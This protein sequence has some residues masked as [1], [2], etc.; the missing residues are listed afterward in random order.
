MAFFKALSLDRAYSA[1][2]FAFLS[3]LD[4][5]PDSLLQGVRGLG[6]WPAFKTAVSVQDTRMNVYFI[7]PPQGDL[8][9]VR[10]VGARRVPASRR[11]Q[12]AELLARAN[13]LLSLG[14]LTLDLD[15]GEIAARASIDSEGMDLNAKILRNLLYTVVSSMQEFYPAVVKLVKSD[16]GVEDC[17][18]ELTET[19]KVVELSM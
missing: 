8:L 16:L 1:F 5:L 10:A 15:D 17:L 9:I 12:V 7:A 14:V 2:S 4:P 13:L 19:R 18:R 6:S 3:L 11:S